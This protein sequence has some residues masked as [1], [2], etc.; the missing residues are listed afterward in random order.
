MKDYDQVQYVVWKNVCWSSARDP[1]PNA[2]NWWWVN[3]I[4]AMPT[5]NCSRHHLQWFDNCCYWCGMHVDHVFAL[6]LCAH[7]ISCTMWQNWEFL[8]K[9]C[10]ASYHIPVKVGDL[11]KV[12]STWVQQWLPCHTCA[13]HH[14]FPSLAEEEGYILWLHFYGGQVIVA[15][16]HLI[17]YEGHF[18]S[19]L[20]AVCV[21]CRHAKPT[22]TFIGTRYTWCS[23]FLLLYL[24]LHTV[25]PWCNHDV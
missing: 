25:Q 6:L 17:L 7:S 1:H 19:F 16:I 10:F 15:F 13:A 11:W 2:S 4:N 24:T 12:G 23:I 3:A 9:M 8:Q 20:H 22:E 5:V 14:P 18:R 21:Y